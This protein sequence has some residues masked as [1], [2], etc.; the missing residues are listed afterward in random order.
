MGISKD[1]AVQIVFRA[2]PVNER[3]KLGAY[4]DGLHPDV[5]AQWGIPAQQQ[6]DEVIVDFI[7]QKMI[8]R[9]EERGCL[10]MN[11]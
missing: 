1:E 4:L 11:G 3:G 6:P 9:G 7:R 5:P 8:D 2:A 10:S